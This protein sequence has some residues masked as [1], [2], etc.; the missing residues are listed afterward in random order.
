MTVS[1]ENWPNK[2]RARVVS[3]DYA[4]APERPYPSGLHDC[5]DAAGWLGSCGAEIGIDPIGS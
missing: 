3:L 2:L 1:P 4:L 5:V